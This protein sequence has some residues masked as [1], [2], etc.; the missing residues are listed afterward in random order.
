M[1]MMMLLDFLKSLKWNLYRWNQYHQDWKEKIGQ[2]HENCR[3]S[4]GITI[5]HPENLHLGEG[6]IIERGT[7]INAS[8]G[9][10]IGAHSVISSNCAIWTGNHRYIDGTKL[11]YGDESLNDGV[12]IGDSV[13]MGHGSMIVPGVRVGEGSVIG[14]G[15][16]VTKDVP[17]L[18]VVGGN[19]ARIIKV[20]NEEHYYQLKEQKSFYR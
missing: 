17:Q 3:L 15:A 6:V 13:W 12:H 7:I 18:S 5:S 16:V 14:M 4:P 1:S 8:A 10:S 9:V 11:P 19:P 2:I 20:R